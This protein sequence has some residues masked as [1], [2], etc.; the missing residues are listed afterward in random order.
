MSFL[1]N[2][3]RSILSSAP[4][5]KTEHDRLIPL[6]NVV[7]LLLAFFIIAGTFRAADATK[8]SPPTIAADGIAAKA[9]E[10]VFIEPDGSI[11]VKGARVTDIESAIIAL[12]QAG[13]QQSK[14]LHIK[15]DKKAPAN[16]LL[17]LLAALKKSGHTTVQLIVVK[18]TP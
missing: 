17:S 5:Q 1:E 2:R 10:T 13:S 8:V 11:F 4:R 6:I 7:F 3:T 12:P 9:G 18:A 16:V 14:P 15:A